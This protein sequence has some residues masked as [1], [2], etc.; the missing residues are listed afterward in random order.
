MKR[1][2]DWLGKEAAPLYGEHIY[3]ISGNHDY[4]EKQARLRRDGTRPIV[5]VGV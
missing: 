4:H 5:S 1:F 3:V 2:N